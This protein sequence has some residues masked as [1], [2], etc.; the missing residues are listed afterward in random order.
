MVDFKLDLYWS[1]HCQSCSN[2]SAKGQWVS[3]SSQHSSDDSLSPSSI[4]CSSGAGSRGAGSW[5]AGM[6]SMS[7]L[8]YTF[9]MVC[10][11]WVHSK[12]V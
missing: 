8:P 11:L 10:V 4:G 6:S 9:G 5:M 7:L 3:V 2:S 1:L 12:G